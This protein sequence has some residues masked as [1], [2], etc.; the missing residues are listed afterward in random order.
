MNLNKEYGRNITN[1]EKQYLLDIFEPDEGTIDLIYG[2]IGNGKT[3]CATEMILEDLKKGQ[4][5]YA[6]WRL[7]YHGF[8]ERKSLVH[9]V[10]SFMFPWRK[11]FYKFPAENLKYFDSSEVDIDFLAKI[12]DANVYIDEGQWIFDSYE[13]TSFSKEKRKLILHTRHLNRRLVI[14]TQRPTA[15]QVSARGNVNRYFKCEKWMSWPFLIFRQFQYQDMVGDTVNE[16]L[17]IGR[18]RVFF[19]KKRVLNAYNS[20][21][22][23]E[24]IPRSQ[25]LVVEAFKLSFVDKIKALWQVIGLQANHLPTQDPTDLSQHN[26]GV[27]EAEAESAPTPLHGGHERPRSLKVRWE[28]LESQRGP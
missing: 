27:V 2:R 4:V 1:E 24:G 13:K 5:V 9:V 22:L 15:I 11:T 7:N 28:E 21:Y 19:A 26:S 14:V 8:D 23:R 16:S 12:T 20:K 17:P 3:Y 10:A 25:D 18:P 6:N